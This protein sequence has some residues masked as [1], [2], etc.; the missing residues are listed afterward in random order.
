MSEGRTVS[1]YLESEG[2]EFIVVANE[3]LSHQLIILR[4][5]AAKTGDS[6]SIPFQAY[7]SH[8]KA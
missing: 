7:S 3:R 8:V 6:S 4:N 1:R 2:I 5:N